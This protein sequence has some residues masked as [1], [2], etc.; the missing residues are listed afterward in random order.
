MLVLTYL[1][2]ELLN[3]K[4]YH[5]CGPNLAGGKE[6]NNCARIHFSFNFSG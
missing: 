5:K 3:E 1:Q 2:R 4:V 6:Q